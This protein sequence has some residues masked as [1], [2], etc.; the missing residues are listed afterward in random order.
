MGLYNTA[1]IEFLK[2]ELADMKYNM[3]RVF[4]VVRHYEKEFQ[5]IYVV[6]DEIRNTLSFSISYNVA[7]LDAKLGRLEAAILRRL[8]KITHALQVALT[9][10]L[11]VDYLGAREVRSIYAKVQER[12]EELNCQLLITQHSDLYQIE[13]SLLPMVP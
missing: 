12:A 6:F 5:Q 8:E 2:T 7:L 9:R 11:S 10:R 3:Q 13:T 4:D 1:Q